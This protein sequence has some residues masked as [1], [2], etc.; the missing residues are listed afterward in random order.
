MQRRLRAALWICA[1]VLILA[2]QM[3]YA[4]TGAIAGLVR[5]TSGGALPG[6]TVEVT[7]PALIEKVRTGITDG[8]GRYLIPALPVGSYSV[9]FTL[10]GFGTTTRENVQVTS[11]FTA[12]VAADMKVGNLTQEVTVSSEAPLVDVQTPRQAVRF[13]SEDLRALPTTRNINSLLSLTPGLST[14][15]NRVGSLQGVCV[16]GIGVFCNPGLPGFTQGDNGSAFDTPGFFGGISDGAGDANLAQGRVLVDGQVINA[17]SNQLIG[18][19]TGGYTADIVNAQEVT[20]QLNGALGESE[21]G[22]ATIN[23]V[24]RTGG[25]R[26]SGEFN[27]TYLGE[28]FFDRN[29]SK[30]DPDDVPTLL[31]LVRSDY[32]VSGGVGGPIMR[33]RLW[34]YSVVRQQRT[35]KL[36]VGTDIWENLHEGQWGYNYQPDRSKPRLEYQ[37][38]WR[39]GNARITLQASQRNKFNIFWDEQDFCQDPCHGIV[40]ITASPESWSSNQIRPN[41]LQ[42]I[43]WTNP[44]SG[45]LL[46]EAGLNVSAGHYNTTEHRQYRNPREI[47]RISESGQSI[48]TDDAPAMGPGGDDVARRLNAFVVN[49]LTS[50]SVDGGFFEMRKTDNYRTTASA[51]YI[52]GSHNAK[53]GWDGAY[54]FQD[55]YTEVN[56]PRLT[57]TY[58]QPAANCATNNTCGSVMAAQF[59]QEALL[60]NPF[61]RPRP[62]SVTFSTGHR[63]L[64]DRVWYGA[65]YAQEQWTLNR[66]TLTGALRYDHA[67]SRYGSTCVGGDGEPFARVQADGTRRYCTPE[68]DGVNYNDISPRFGAVWDLFGDGKTAIK[69]NMGKYLQ[70]AGISGLYTGANPARNT[71]N[72]LSRN[73]T[74]TNADRMVDCDLLNTAVNGE[75]GTFTSSAASV[76]RYGLDPFTSPLGLATVQCGREGGDVIIQQVAQ[77]YCAAYGDSLL[78]GWGKRRYEWQLGLGVQREI[79]PRLSGEVTYNRRLYRNLTSDD[80]IGV[81]CDRFL[82]AQDPRTCQEAYLDYQG[83]AFTDFYEYVAPLDPRLPGGG[84]YRVLGLTTGRATA[85]SSGVT[86]QTLDPERNYYWHGVDTN[87]AWRAPFGLRVNGGTSTSRTSRETC[88]AAYDGPGGG[89]TGREGQEYGSGCR[90]YIPFQTRINGTATYTIPWVDV[91]VSTVFQSIPGGEISAS[92]QNVLATDPNITWLRPERLNEPCTGTAQGDPGNPNR[93]CF[94]TTRNALDGDISILLDNEMWGERTTLFDLKFAKNLRFAGRRLQVGV[95][96]YN[97][98]NSDA[99][100]SYEGDY[101]PTNQ[102]WLEPRSVVQPRVARFSVQFSF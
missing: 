55:Q 57:Y 89:F 91:L 66:F 102:E 74:D 7:S 71:V 100:Q 76:A 51:S 77:D 10:P 81:G 25:N 45:R 99:I 3:A 46:L 62:S 12:N 82:G 56:D 87:F 101:D 95:D 9:K 79:L 48:G 70:S 34:F 8:N 13:S 26:F 90:R 6:V 23:I 53:V 20:I 64:K 14:D 67:E 38:Y 69:W 68:T 42:Q 5:D 96:V 21:T 41:R 35:H 1:S 33:D 24:P 65:L 60:G 58:T 28:K 86:V 73:W 88:F 4:Q 2:P 39:N 16:G 97:V 30:F 54:Y 50:G 52:T 85:P 36:P 15:Y 44:F 18:G 19:M 17:S 43:K 59:P 47:P 75:C 37:N 94:G 72:T 83:D 98:F 11:D 93:G 80:V 40:A 61:R 49:G 63:E 92:V 29:T 32:D 27:T 78:N 84:G 31:Q 22:G